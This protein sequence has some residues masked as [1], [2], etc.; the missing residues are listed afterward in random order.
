VE[1]V[2]AYSFPIVPP[3]N[4][5]AGELEVLRLAACAHTTALIDD[6][7]ACRFAERV[8]VPVVR[9]LAILARDKHLGSIETVRPL[10]E[11]M[12]DHGI[13]LSPD[14]L[15]RFLKELGGL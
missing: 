5:G 3:A 2:Q 9:S 15:S 8:G 11:G 13:R 6:S 1:P 10:V 7:A 14:L 4:L 12:L